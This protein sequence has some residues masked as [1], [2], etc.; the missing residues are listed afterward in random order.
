MSA[1][2]SSTSEGLHF[3]VN[4]KQIGSGLRKGSVKRGWWRGYLLEDRLPRRLVRHECATDGCLQR[5]ISQKWCIY[6]LG[7]R[8]SNPHWRSQSPQ[9]YH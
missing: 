7:E 2:R 3:H 8:D 9:S 4:T 6:W 1:G 5:L